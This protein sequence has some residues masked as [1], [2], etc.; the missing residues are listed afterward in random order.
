MRCNAL[1]DIER[2]RHHDF[3][4]NWYNPLVYPLM[5]WFYNVT[6]FAV[7]LWMLL[8]IEVVGVCRQCLDRS[9]TSFRRYL[10]RHNGT[11]NGI[12]VCTVDH[13]RSCQLTR[14]KQTALLFQ[15]RGRGKGRG[16]EDKI[17]LKEERVGT[18][19]RGSERGRRVRIVYRTV[20]LAV[21]VG[22]AQRR[23]E[24][25]ASGAFR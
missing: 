2:A 16:G 7:V 6:D 21:Y 22:H 13:R 25:N 18:H 9:K 4:R 1:V 10:A 11:F 17:K 3:Q 5:L 14:L 12:R 19:T 8:P 20:K 24:I 23:M 15:K